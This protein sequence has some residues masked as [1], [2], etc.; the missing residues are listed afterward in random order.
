MAQGSRTLE[1]QI[2]AVIDG[3]A[4]FDAAGVCNARVLAKT[5]VRLVDRQ[6]RTL[7]RHELGDAK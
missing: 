7:S 6:R 4:I 5:I 2:E 3:H 1:Q